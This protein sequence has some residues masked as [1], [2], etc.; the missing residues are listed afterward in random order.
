MKVKIKDLKPN[1]F[2][3][4]KTY[5][6]DQARVERLRQSI[7]HTGFWDNIVGREKDGKVE[8]A[9]G[10]HRLIALQKE[11]SKDYEVDVIIKPLDDARMIQ[12]MAD[13]NDELY[14]M[15][16]AVINETIKVTKDFLIKNPKYI[17][18][19]DIDIPEKD[20]A[21]VISKFLNWPFRRVK[22]TLA[23][24]SAIDN[25]DVDGEVYESFKTQ[26]HAEEWRKCVKKFPEVSQD[27]AKKI[28]NKVKTEHL[29]YREVKD[30]FR[31]EKFKIHRP[32]PKDYLED[33]VKLIPKINE[34]T[35]ELDKIV[36]HKNSI[37]GREGENFRWA[38][39]D[40]LIVLQKF[41]KKGE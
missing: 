39:A 16:P 34:L 17:P 19:K 6:I 29:G 33:F 32:K 23:A 30:K 18:T 35:R 4:L 28:A 26:K 24:I 1:P 9:Y 15:C 27:V 7:K 25:G 20:W 11:Y 38:V 12:V 31:E 41:T 22:D 21:K 3:R 36:E 2:R 14:A 40:L 37:T 10:H 8:I 5:P 13:E